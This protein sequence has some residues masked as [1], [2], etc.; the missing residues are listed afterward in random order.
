VRAEEVGERW[1]LDPDA[2][3]LVFPR[4]GRAFGLGDK[5]RVEV[6]SASPQQRRIEFRFA[7]LAPAPPPAGTRSPARAK[8]R[9]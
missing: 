1:E 6:L 8:Q 7:G 2:H 3:R 9:R 5:V 4:L